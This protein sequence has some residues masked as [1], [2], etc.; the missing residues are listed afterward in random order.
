MLACFLSSLLVDY[1]LDVVD[2][3]PLDCAVVHLSESLCRQV[4]NQT[5]AKLLL[6]SAKKE[7]VKCLLLT[8]QEFLG[9][10]LCRSSVGLL[11][12]LLE[13]LQDLLLV[14]FCRE[15]DCETLAIG[16]SERC[17]D[18]CQRSLLLLVED[19][20]VVHLVLQ[21]VSRNFDRLSVKR[22]A[23]NLITFVLDRLIVASQREPVAHG[24]TRAVPFRLAFCLLSFL[25][26]R[27][28]CFGPFLK[29]VLGILKYDAL[30]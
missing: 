12:L 27:V 29:D 3:E 25:R 18:V 10:G 23:Y 1:V 7:S 30:D 6:R 5:P 14:D 9:E 26:I 4:S 13:L 28:R 11:L 20:G 15:A 24:E 22:L 16:F 8:R 21:D 17:G 2:D 19:V